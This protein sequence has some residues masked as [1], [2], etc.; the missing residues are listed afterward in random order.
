MVHTAVHVCA[1]ELAGAR[2]EPAA[3]I[4]A[5]ERARI[6]CDQLP[7]PYLAAQLAERVACA[8][9]D[10]GER[11]AAGRLADLADTFDGLGATRDA[12][13]CRHLA[14]RNG[15]TQHSRRGRRGYGD[16][17]SPREHDVARLLATGRTNREIAEV[18]FLSRRTVEQHVA[19]V[20]HK[21]GVGSRRDLLDLELR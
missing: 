16:E 19:N 4:T 5:F 21:L 6:Q 18:L 15:A 12:A 13:R 9:L 1:A 17:L 7:R 14:R 10:L 8:R 11:D 3:A 2:G 20:L